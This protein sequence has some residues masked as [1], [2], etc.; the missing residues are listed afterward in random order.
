MNMA[1]KGRLRMDRKI[2]RLDTECDEAGLHGEH[3][4][5]LVS[6]GFDLT[7]GLCYLALIEG[8]RFQC[9]HCGRKARNSRNLCVPRQIGD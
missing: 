6:Q 1:L 3:L 7:D 4:C 9:D 2:E 5:Y 8:P